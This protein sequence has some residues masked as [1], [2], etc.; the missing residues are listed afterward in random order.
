MTS[1]LDEY[2]F[3]AILAIEAESAEQ[4]ADLILDH[5]MDGIDIAC[6][7]HK[8]GSLNV[9]EA[10]KRIEELESQLEKVR[11]AAK[12]EGAYLTGAGI[13]SLLEND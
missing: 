11:H 1:R 4:A 9:K 6:S 3:D 8:E 10:S 2:T 5:C 13:L 12:T 7:L